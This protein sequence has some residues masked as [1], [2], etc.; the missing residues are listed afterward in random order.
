MTD[1]DPSLVEPLICGLCEKP[2]EAERPAKE[3][4]RCLRDL[5]RVRRHY[6]CPEGHVS[7]CADVEAINAEMK[8]LREGRR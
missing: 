1:A 2:L 3:C 5:P 6:R 7:V 4:K 8:A